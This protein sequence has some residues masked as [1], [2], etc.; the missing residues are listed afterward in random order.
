M[1]YVVVL[2]M[3]LLVGA[4]LLGLLYFALSREEESHQKR[5]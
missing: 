3:I 4:F 5:R 2:V 1:V